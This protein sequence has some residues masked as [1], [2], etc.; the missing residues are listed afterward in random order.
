MRYRCRL[1]NE[2]INVANSSATRLQRTKL[3]MRD[4][5]DIEP[6]MFTYDQDRKILG[7]CSVCWKC[8]ATAGGVKCLQPLELPNCCAY[9]SL[10]SIESSLPA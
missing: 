3:C 8:G 5:I 9:C 6:F 2:C 10:S 7:V 4:V 1:V